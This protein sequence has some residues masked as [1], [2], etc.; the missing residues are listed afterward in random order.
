MDGPF[1]IDEPAAGAIARRH[2]FRDVWLS[3]LRWA[4]AVR[5]IG[6]LNAGGNLLELFPLKSDYPAMGA[7]GDPDQ[8]RLL[9]VIQAV[10]SAGDFYRHEGL[11]GE[12]SRLTNR[13][14]AG[15]E[16]G[17]IAVEI[18]KSECRLQLL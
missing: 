12:A 9:R 4:E 8:D 1:G 5:T 14:I 2:S 11:L 3:R 16:T 13:E 17:V 7:A 10:C 18:L 15:S 6:E